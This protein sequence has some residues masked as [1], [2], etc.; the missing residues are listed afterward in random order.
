MKPEWVELY[1]WSHKHLFIDLSL[2]YNCPPNFYKIGSWTDGE[3]IY[4]LFNWSFGIEDNLD[5]IIEIPYGE[6]WHEWKL[7]SQTYHEEYAE[8]LRKKPGEASR[9]VEQGP[10]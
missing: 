7:K 10:P 4:L 8:W 3:K 6:W 1:N 5:K 2:L 9:L